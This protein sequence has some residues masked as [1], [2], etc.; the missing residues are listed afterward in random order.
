MP[1]NVS[2]LEIMT[3]PLNNCYRLCCEFC[4]QAGYISCMTHSQNPDR[5]SVD[6]SDLQNLLD[7]DYPIDK[8]V[9]SAPQSWSRWRNHR[10]PGWK[11]NRQA[12]KGVIPQCRSS[13]MDHSVHITEYTLDGKAFLLMSSRLTFDV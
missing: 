4:T 6:S 12:D 8:E 11:D 1:S 10:S 5:G 2:T 13:R 9:I 7:L 3:M